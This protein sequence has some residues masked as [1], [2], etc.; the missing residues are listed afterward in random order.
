M[1]NSYWINTAASGILMENV[2]EYT[3]NMNMNGKWMGYKWNMNG[4]LI[5][6]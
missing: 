6:I 3:W 2:V 1:E 4:G 5:Y